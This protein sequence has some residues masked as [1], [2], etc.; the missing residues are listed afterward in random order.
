MVDLPQGTRIYP[1][2]QSEKMMNSSPNVSVSVNVQ[3][4]IFGLENAAELIGDMVCGKIVETIR[5]IIFYGR[6]SVLVLAEQRQ[7]GIRA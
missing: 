4:N 3:G 5:L 6:G 2:S 7:Q 1:H